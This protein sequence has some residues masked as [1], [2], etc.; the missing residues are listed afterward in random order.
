MVDGARKAVVN[1]DMCMWGMRG[2]ARRLQKNEAFECSAN[3]IGGH[4]A[5]AAPCK[6][7]VCEKCATFL[8]GRSHGLLVDESREHAFTCA[9]CMGGD[10][11][12]MVATL[13]GV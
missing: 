7:V 12:N 2:C 1:G 3:N 8:Y 5:G 9:V 6:G 13:R 4:S 10:F 11:C